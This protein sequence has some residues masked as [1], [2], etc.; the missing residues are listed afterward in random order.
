MPDG[1]DP[2]GGGW[3]PD[4]GW[5]EELCPRPPAPLGNVTE[6]SANGPRGKLQM[7]HLFKKMEEVSLKKARGG[8]PPHPH[9]GLREDTPLPRATGLPLGEC[10]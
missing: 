3:L 2:A 6:A 1:P 7:E 5:S 8:A 4:R 10:A 9:P